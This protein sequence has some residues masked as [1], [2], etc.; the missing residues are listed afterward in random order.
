MRGFAMMGEMVSLVTMRRVVMPSNVSAPS[1]MPTMLKLVMSTMAVMTAMLKLVMATVLV[2]SFVLKMVMP[3][4]LVMAV[5]D[6]V[7]ATM[8][9]AAS[10]ILEYP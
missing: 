5:P 10:P 9:H 7:S 3:S 6:M 1:N 8:P 4:M 2:M